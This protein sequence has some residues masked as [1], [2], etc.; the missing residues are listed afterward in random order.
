MATGRMD[1]GR[2]SLWLWK[3]GETFVGWSGE[4]GPKKEK[5]SK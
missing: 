1:G 3:Y 2:T 5:G 4:R